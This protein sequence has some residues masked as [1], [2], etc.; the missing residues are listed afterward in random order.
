MSVV[1]IVVN[2]RV[3]DLDTEAIEQVRSMVHTLLP[4][5]RNPARYFER[6]SE[7]TGAL[8][9]L[10]R[11][12]GNEPRTLNGRSVALRVVG[13][14]GVH[15]G[16]SGALALRLRAEAVLGLVEVPAEPEAAVAPPAAR[17]SGYAR[18]RVSRQ[19][20]RHKYPLPPRSAAAIGVL[21]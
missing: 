10:I 15:I 3:C 19:S 9:K 20:R 11:L 2:N 7:I 14:A 8:T 18:V 5:W 6:R 21:L 17:Q 4:D 1:S 12:L 13:G 16:P